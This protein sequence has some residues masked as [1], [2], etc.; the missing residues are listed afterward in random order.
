MR[1]EIRGMRVQLER[2]ER[3]VTS[4]RNNRLD[5]IVRQMKQSA[6]DLLRLT[7]R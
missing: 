3:I 5:G 6:R 2:I 1:A 4:E 7:E